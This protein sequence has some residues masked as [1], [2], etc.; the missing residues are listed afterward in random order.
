MVA[1]VPLRHPLALAPRIDA[2]DLRDDM[3]VAAIVADE[4][5]AVMG[6]Q[7]GKRAAAQALPVISV[8]QAI[9]RAL[10]D[11]E[12]VVLSTQRGVNGPAGLMLKATT[13]FDQDCLA[14][15]STTG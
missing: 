7:L 3:T 1:L 2:R 9:Q 11:G 14:D 8:E 10:I 12:I 4:Q 6:F 15:G 13:G 5:G